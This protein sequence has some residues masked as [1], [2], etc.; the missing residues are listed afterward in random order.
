M[1]GALAGYFIGHQASQRSA[2]YILP[3]MPTM[4]DL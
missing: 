3:E 1:G 4:P 2:E